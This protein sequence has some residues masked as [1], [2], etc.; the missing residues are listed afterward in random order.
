MF[1]Y[2]RDWSESQRPSR[3]NK[4][5]NINTNMHD[6]NKKEIC[7]GARSVGASAP[8]YIIAEV[9][10]AHEGSL[11]AAHAYIDSA[12]AAGADAVKFQTHS[13]DWESSKYEDFRVRVF[14]QDESRS[15]YW[16][17]TSFAKQ[18]WLELAAHSRE[19]EID[20]LSS[21]F[22]HQAVDLLE[23][24]GVPAW[25]IASGEV[26]NLPMLEH[27][28]STQ[29]PVL[30][31]SGMSS[32]SE[33]VETTQYLE[34][35][36]ISYGLF[37]CTTSYPCPPEIWGLNVIAEM[38]HRFSCPIGLSDHSGTIIPSL[39]SIQLGASMLEC[40]V[41]F[42]K[43]QFGPDSEASLTFA[44]F[45]EMVDGVRQMERALENPVDKDKFARESSKNR[46]LFSKSLFAARD[47]DEG[48]ALEP[49]D[50]SI[51]KPCIG[52]PARNFNLIVGKKVTRPILA[53][54]PIL[55]EA[56][57]ATDR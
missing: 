35:L 26:T 29:K 18:H 55:P 30:V 54:E 13:A 42:S 46:E 15:A 24:C 49:T 27:I 31:S 8:T 4:N 25:K 33:L 44:Q 2:C 20:F 36:G 14:P 12:A 37:Q 32:W 53:G 19:L 9:G 52:V 40:H 50:I 1:C 21:P 16:N 7:I 3:V 56:I 22:S 38:Q 39:A 5:P 23:E 43:K 10:L 6:A 17:R 57:E 34:D 41:A 48:T 28:A 11:G 51:L 47:L 45:K